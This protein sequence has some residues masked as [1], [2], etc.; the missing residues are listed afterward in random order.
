MRHNKN[1][2]NHRSGKIRKPKTF[3]TS[4]MKTILKM[5]RLASTLSTWKLNVCLK[6]YPVLTSS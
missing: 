6:D 4:N 5:E 1:I 3:D 2:P